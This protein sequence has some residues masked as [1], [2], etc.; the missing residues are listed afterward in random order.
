MKRASDSTFFYYRPPG[1]DPNNRQQGSF[2]PNPLPTTATTTTSTP[3]PPPPPPM[4]NT[5]EM[6]K[7]QPARF[8]EPPAPPQA[9]TIPMPVRSLPGPPQSMRLQPEDCNRILHD[10]SKHDYQ[11]GR[12]TLAA[13]NPA[14]PIPIAMPS[15]SRQPSYDVS[16]TSAIGPVPPSPA[17]R[18]VG[19]EHGVGL[20]LQQPWFHCY[21]T[22]SLPNSPPITPNRATEFSMEAHQMPTPVPTQVPIYTPV[23]TPAQTPNQMA[24]QTPRVL[25]AIP[26]YSGSSVTATLQT[27]Q[28]NVTDQAGLG[29]GLGL[30]LGF[31]S[32]DSMLMPSMPTL[33][34]DDELYRTTVRDEHRF[35]AMASTATD[36]LGTATTA[37]I[38][39]NHP[40]GLSGPEF[41]V[42]EAAQP[43][44]PPSFRAFSDL[45]SEDDTNRRLVSF[46]PTNTNV[47]APVVS[48]TWTISPSEQAADLA[49]LGCHPGFSFDSSEE[50]E[51][52]FVCEDVLGPLGCPSAVEQP[53]PVDYNEMPT[54][55]ALASSQ[56]AWHGLHS[57]LDSGSMMATGPVPASLVAP[58]DADQSNSEGDATSGSKT[59]TKTK[60]KTKVKVKRKA[61]SAFAGDSNATDTNAEASFAAAAATV[62]ATANVQNPFSFQ[63]MHG[64]ST[65]DGAQ[66]ALP[67]PA[68]RR[69]RKQPSIDDLTKQYKCEECDQRFRRQEHL[70]RHHRSL[71]TGH[72]PHGCPRCPKSFSRS[73]NLTQHLRTHGA[74]SVPLKG[75]GN[76]VNRAGQR[77]DPLPDPPPASPLPPSPPAVAGQPNA[78]NE[79]ANVLY[80]EFHGALGNTSSASDQSPVAIGMITSSDASPPNAE[81]TGRSSARDPTSGRE[82]EDAHASPPAGLHFAHDVAAARTQQ[83]L[84]IRSHPPTKLR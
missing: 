8:Q 67:K 82:G 81:H 38:S 60:T 15:P 72:K 68:N 21:H 1:L 57:S 74:G 3:P 26:D 79:A 83:L 63:P 25:G 12:L 69:G 2:S 24:N 71:H 14:T 11:A 28:W 29:L 47:S 84:H 9:W 6:K 40:S 13:P 50:D 16:S 76:A 37:T 55:P 22:R 10:R 53:S 77:S 62:T 4:P 78:T 51:S 64:N 58:S 23:Q 49:N 44:P 46:V 73:D 56:R 66:P 17:T 7:Q 34:A 70:K 31:S 33:S 36:V 5:A 54:P 43:L 32:I 39:D 30:G 35:G 18:W 27:G 80:N 59:K 52:K 20:G 61:D 65:S 45:D 75:K 41:A 48:A 42:T 19:L